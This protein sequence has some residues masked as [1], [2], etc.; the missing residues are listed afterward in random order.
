MD[1]SLMNDSVFDVDDEGGSSDFV[2]EPA[3]VWISP[4]THTHDLDPDSYCPVAP[5]PWNSSGMNF[6]A[7]GRFSVESQS[8]I[9]SSSHRDSTWIMNCIPYW[10]LTAISW[11]DGISHWI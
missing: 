4:P 5:D 11:M 2:P 10:T 7:F 1:D 9:L 8:Q 6:N 3:P